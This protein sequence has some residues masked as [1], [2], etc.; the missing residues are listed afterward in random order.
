MAMSA[1][2]VLGFVF[3]SILQGILAEFQGRQSSL[4]WQ[5][6]ADDLGTRNSYRRCDAQANSLIFML[7]QKKLT[8]ASLQNRNL[9]V[10]TRKS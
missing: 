4:L 9:S 1:E 7:N 6:R 10:F 2:M 8:E 5:G 3:V